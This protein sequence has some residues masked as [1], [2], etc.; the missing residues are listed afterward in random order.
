MPRAR[1]NIADHKGQNGICS[2]MNIGAVV[3]IGRELAASSSTCCVHA[4][5]F[6][7]SAN[8]VELTA[9]LGVGSVVFFD[10]GKAKV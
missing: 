3:G 8:P 10:V 1:G 5:I 7:D 9:L 2:L 6:G 4:F